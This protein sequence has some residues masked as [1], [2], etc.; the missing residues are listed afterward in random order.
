MHGPECSRCVC[1][2]KFMVAIILNQNAVPN[3]PPLKILGVKILNNFFS[4]LASQ[5]LNQW[6]LK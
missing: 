3:P 4:L 1:G 2:P 6:F 5:N